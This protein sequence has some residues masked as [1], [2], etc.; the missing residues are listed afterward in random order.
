MLRSGSRL[1]SIVHSSLANHVH[2]FAR[3]H[4]LAGGF[5]NSAFARSVRLLEQSPGPR[6]E[7]C[8]ELALRAIVLLQCRFHDLEPSVCVLVL[9]PVPVN[10]GLLQPSR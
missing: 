3:C 6:R 7:L 9:H 1:I 2:D 8:E 10:N 5:S 4:S